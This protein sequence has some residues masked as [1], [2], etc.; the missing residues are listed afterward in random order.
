[1]EK[2]LS[3]EQHIKLA[4]STRYLELVLLPTESCNF[5]CI[6]CYEAHPR[7][8]MPP[9]V[10][11]G[12]K[13]LI[14]LRASSLATLNIIWFGGEPLLAKSI[15]QEVML[16]ALQAKK[17]NPSLNLMSTVYTNGY[18]L[19]SETAE[20]LARLGIGWFHVTL[21]GWGK[22]HDSTRKRADGEETFNKIWNNLL[23]LHRSSLEVQ[24]RLRI[25]YLVQDWGK[26]ELLLDK[27]DDEFGR[28]ERFN[29]YFRP[30]CRWGSPNDN[31]I[32]QCSTA[33]H[34]EISRVLK[35]MVK[36]PKMIADIPDVPV[37]CYAAQTNSFVIRSNGDIV[38]C[39]IP[40]DA[41]GN[42]VGRIREDSSFY[43]DSRK[44]NQWVS[45]LGS[46]GNELARAC[47]WSSYLKEVRKSRC[48]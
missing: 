33:E 29:F 41:P 26:V 5:N 23:A 48:A 40:L 31:L 35:K 28:D 8:K 7:G 13:K 44:I 27:I 45:G 10:V 9:Y 24:F 15:I 3:L 4:L 1:M 43:I 14:N 16:R 6:Y 32:E 2:K 36:N 19:D 30:I 42:L 21:D 25:H 12:I 34:Q 37:V 11:E 17:E 20:S 22:Q 46:K 38:K 18:L 47:P 39:A